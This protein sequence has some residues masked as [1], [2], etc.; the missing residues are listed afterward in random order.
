MIPP[1]HWNE[2][3]QHVDMLDQTKLPLEEVWLE[4]KT[5]AAMAEAIKRLS[6]RGAPA[7][8]IAASYGVV[9]AFNEPIDA[10]GLRPHLQGVIDHLASTRPTAVNLFWALDR[11]RAVLESA[12]TEDREQLNALLLKEAIKIHKEDL[13]AGEK[14]G[15]YG[16]EVLKDG[17]RV[18]THCHAGGVATSGYGTALAPLLMSKAKGVHLEAIVNETRPLL[19]G[20]RITAWELQ[21]MDVPTTLITDSMAGHAMQQG[22]VDAIIVGADRIASN[23]DVANKIGTYALSVLANAHKIPFY[24]SAPCSTIDRQIEEGKDIIIE[25]RADHEITQ[26]FG[27][28]TAPD[29]IGVYNPAFDVTPAALIAAIITERGVVYS[30]TK[31]RIA[32]LFKSL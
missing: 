2:L 15:L 26:G 21:K 28:Q 14:L 30:P 13:A 24:V 1:L 29:N 23:G 5:P 10:S 20:S 27:R 6:V 17:M 3:A 32:A 18:M 25:Q 31:E 19:Q 7:I 12:K 22:M 16:L 4:I 9:L 8:G 11:M